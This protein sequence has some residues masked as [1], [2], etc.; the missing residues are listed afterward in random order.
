MVVDRE[1]RQSYQ[2]I[3]ARGERTDF[4]GRI[5]WQPNSFRH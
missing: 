3:C 2:H 5:I 4:I 1:F